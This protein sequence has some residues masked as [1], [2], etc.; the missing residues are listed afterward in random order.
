M[1]AFP[2]VGVTVVISNDTVTVMNQPVD[3]A[4]AD[5]VLSDEEGDGGASVNGDEED[6]QGREDGETEETGEPETEPSDDE[7]AE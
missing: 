3:I 1:N 4:T 7:E 6:E 2:P 5:E